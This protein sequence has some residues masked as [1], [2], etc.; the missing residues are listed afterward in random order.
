MSKPL[1]APYQLLL[2]HYLKGVDK[3]QLSTL[4]GLIM[5]LG[6]SAIKYYKS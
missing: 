6:L 1:P 4:R 2:N 3:N 5:D